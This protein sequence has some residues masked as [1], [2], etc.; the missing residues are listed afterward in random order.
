MYVCI[1]Q[2]VTEQDIKNHMVKGRASMGQLCKQLG[3]AS[4]CGKCAEHVREV[5]SSALLEQ[6]AAIA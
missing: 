6:Q 2:A 4:Q 3:C 5:H 1:C